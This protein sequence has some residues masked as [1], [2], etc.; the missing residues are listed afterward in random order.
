[1]RS[2]A[3]GGSRNRPARSAKPKNLG[4]MQ[5]GACAL[6]P[7]DHGEVILVSVQPG[8]EHD[9]GLVEAR[10]RREDQ[11]RQRHGRREDV[12]EAGLVARGEPRQRRRGGRRDR[13][14]DA[15]QRVGMALR[16]RR[17]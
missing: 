9:A 2:A 5:D 3:S 12:V 4:E 16:R 11:P 17:R 13:I 7:A 6:L 14:E 15:E 10:R 1:M 8:E